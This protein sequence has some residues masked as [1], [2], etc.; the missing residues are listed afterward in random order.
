MLSQSDSIKRRT[1]NMIYNNKTYTC[2]RMDPSNTFIQCRRKVLRT[3][4]LKKNEAQFIPFFVS[5]FYLHW[6]LSP[7]KH[8]RL[9]QPFI[10]FNQF[11]KNTYLCCSSAALFLSAS[12]SCFSLA[13]SLFWASSLSFF[14][15]ASRL[16]LSSSALCLASSVVCW[17]MFSNRARKLEAFFFGTENQKAKCVH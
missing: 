7:F 11:C 8:S 14:S 2:T 13:S 3:F 1:L 15:R 17:A 10:S 4:W 9:I 12:S 16:F 6:P 5:S